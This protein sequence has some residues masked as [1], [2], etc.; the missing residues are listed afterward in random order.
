[1]PTWSPKSNELYFLNSD[2]RVMVATFA[3]AGDT[4]RPDA[5]RQWSG[6]RVAP[7]GAGRWFNLHPDGE[8]FVVAVGAP[9]REDSARSDAR[10]KNYV[11]VFN[12]FDELRRRVPATR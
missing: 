1:L 3:V 4:F 11:F 5:P 12:F 6:T 8:R 7:R 9:G 10:S 2:V